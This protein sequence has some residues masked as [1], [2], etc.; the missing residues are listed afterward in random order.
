MTALSTALSCGA[1]P[2]LKGVVVQPEHE[3]HTQLVAACKAR[4]IVIE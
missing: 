4:G 1:L 3:D 2:A